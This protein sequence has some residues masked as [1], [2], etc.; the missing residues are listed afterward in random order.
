MASTLLLA[1]WLFPIEI[2]AYPLIAEVEVEKC[3]KYN[4][5]EDDDAHMIFVVIPGEEKE[6][7]E[8]YWVTAIGE[9]SKEGGANFPTEMP[10][11]PEEIEKLMTAKDEMSKV[12]LRI[13]KPHYRALRE[14]VMKNHKPVIFNNVVKAAQKKGMGN[15][16]SLEGWTI[17][18]F[19]QMEGI[20]KVVF[21]VVMVSYAGQEEESEE[22]KKK[23]KIIKKEHLTPLEQ[24]FNEAMLAAD[25]I[26]NE[27]RYM[28]RRE[29][30]MRHT[31]DS[32]N[33]RVRYFSYLSVVVLLGTAW[34]QIAYLK[35][36]FKKKKLM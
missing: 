29:Q 5:P 2:S 24:N 28:E 7:V 35:S 20:S 16:V 25:K 33:R 32:T 1:I 36:Y 12:R 31:A 6:E 30:R 27:M 14:I 34:L 19:N 11:V 13:Q 18:F 23:R 4:I 17:C 22:E 3:F 10:P 15:D 26:L 9:L 21:D 8:D